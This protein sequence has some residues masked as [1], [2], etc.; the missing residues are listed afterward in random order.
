MITFVENAIT[1][2]GNVGL[3]MDGNLTYNPSSGTL[4]ATAFSGDG[5]NITGISAQVSI[6]DETSDTTCFPLFATSATGTQDLKSA[7]SKLTYNSSTGEF[8]S[9]VFKGK[10]AAEDAS[11]NT[12]RVTISN[13]AP[14]NPGT[15]DIWI[16]I[17]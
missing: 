10:G 8:A 2:S 6:G 9:T 14:S 17:S 4:S 5:T 15:G 3:E 11:G 16:D 12:V 7:A 13:S 1:S